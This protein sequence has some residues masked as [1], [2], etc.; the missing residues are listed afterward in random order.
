MLLKFLR[1]TSYFLIGVLLSS[2]ACFAWAG[3]YPATIKYRHG[4]S[5]AI[6]S[7]FEEACQ[8][9]IAQNPALTYVR[10]D[11]YQGEGWC[12]A[13]NGSSVYR[14]GGSYREASCPNGGAVS[15]LN[16]VKNCEAGEELLDSGQCAPPC[17][18]G[19]TRQPDGSCANPCTV[20]APSVA[21]SY[22]GMWAIGPGRDDQVGNPGLPSLL[23]S[24]QCLGRP[25]MGDSIILS[26]TRSN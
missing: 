22:N 5:P 24:G 12:M 14:A 2:I 4:S 19:Y 10:T 25:A 13:T 6:Y 3:T 23:C 9:A 8:A 11:E 21:H 16:C 15:G 7:S 17:S 26:P 20:D 1:L 18:Q